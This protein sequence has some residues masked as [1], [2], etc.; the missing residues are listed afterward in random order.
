MFC[1]R[2]ETRD[3]SSA[4]RARMSSTVSRCFGIAERIVAMV[5]VVSRD[6]QERG[7]GGISSLSEH[8]AGDCLL[9]LFNRADENWR[10]EGTD[11]QI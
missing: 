2:W 10:E 9:T 7:I 6:G 3:W 11:V 8:I 4:E 5:M 1:R